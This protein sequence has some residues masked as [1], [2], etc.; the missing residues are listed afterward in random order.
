MIDIDLLIIEKIRRD[1]QQAWEDEGRRIQLP[2]PEPELKPKK[3]N[4][5]EPKRVIEIQ[6]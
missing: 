2:L 3:E 5:P 1:Q 4:K 6:L